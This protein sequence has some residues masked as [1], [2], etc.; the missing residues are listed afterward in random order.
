MEE[1]LQGAAPPV[2]ALPPPIKASQLQGK[3]E[4]MV[5]SSQETPLPTHMNKSSLV[6]D[7]PAR[8]IIMSRLSLR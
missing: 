1:D 6:P 8:Q 4:K 3:G 2:T 7:V 5:G